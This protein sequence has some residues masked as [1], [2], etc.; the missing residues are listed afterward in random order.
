MAATGKAFSG[1]AAIMPVI[2]KAGE[3]LYTLR[4]R[5]Q[6]VTAYTHYAVDAFDNDA[7]LVGMYRGSGRVSQYVV[8][9]RPGMLKWCSEVPFLA[10][11][12]LSITSYQR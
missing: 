12:S 3:M 10:K 1:L 4:A 2:E 7:P 5:Q 6:D 11:S 9:A 8:T